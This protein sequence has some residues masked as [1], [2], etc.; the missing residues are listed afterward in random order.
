MN[1]INFMFFAYNQVSSEK[2][3]QIANDCLYM[4]DHFVNKFENSRGENGTQ[5]FFNWFMLLDNDNKK[6]VVNWIETNY[7]NL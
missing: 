3:R 2:I 5:K 4:T 7:K 6:A 1:T